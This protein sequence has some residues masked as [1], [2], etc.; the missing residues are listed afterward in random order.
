MIFVFSMFKEIYTSIILEEIKKV[1]FIKTLSSNGEKYN[2]E[3]QQA[4]NIP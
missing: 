3:I 4:L 2:D 1:I